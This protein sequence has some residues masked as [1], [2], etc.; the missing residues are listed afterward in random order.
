MK[1][2]LN[3][4]IP[5][6]KTNFH[7]L[8]ASSTKLPENALAVIP[9]TKK[10]GFAKLENNSLMKLSAA[11]KTE[12]LQNVPEPITSEQMFLVN[13]NKSLNDFQSVPGIPPYKYN[14]NEDNPLDLSTGISH[15]S[16]KNKESTLPQSSD[17]GWDFLEKLSKFCFLDV[18]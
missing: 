11:N 2:I 1:R 10:D 4:K 14:L 13:K 8:P 17:S 12:K 3:K 15:K 16:P 5:G 18:Y 7:K 6:F 9:L